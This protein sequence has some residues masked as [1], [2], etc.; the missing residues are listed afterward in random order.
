MKNAV[1][2]KGSLALGNKLFQA[3]GK[4]RKRKRAVSL[5]GARLLFSLKFTAA[6]WPDKQAGICTNYL[7][8]PKSIQI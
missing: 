6:L 5:Y 1:P 7:G 8:I 4:I 2:E 3:G